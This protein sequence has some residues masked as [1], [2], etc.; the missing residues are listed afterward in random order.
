MSQ[1]QIRNELNGNTQP[2]ESLGSSFLGSKGIIIA[3]LIAL[4]AAF[5]GLKTF[6]KSED[7]SQY[8]GMLEKV[9]IET[10][11]LKNSTP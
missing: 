3:V 10:Q 6:L 7:S 1:E 8:Q 4:I 11:N 9:R 2:D 5:V